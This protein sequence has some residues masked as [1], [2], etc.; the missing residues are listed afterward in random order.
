MFKS[1]V[2]N[3]V[4]T[5]TVKELNESCYYFLN[6]K[7]FPSCSLAISRKSNVDYVSGTTRCRPLQKRMRTRLRVGRYVRRRNA[8]KKKKS[9]TRNKNAKHVL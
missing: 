2:A 6:R 5:L 3:V 7:A 1:S 8:V 9:C 4:S